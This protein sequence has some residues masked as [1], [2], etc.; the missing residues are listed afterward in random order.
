PPVS[1]PPP[2][3]P[4]PRPRATRARRRAAPA[5]DGQTSTAEV[6][7]ATGG[8]DLASTP[9]PGA[10][11]PP[12]RDGLT[13][14]EPPAPAEPGAKPAR[15]RRTARSATPDAGGAEDENGS[16]RRRRRA[17]AATQTELQLEPIPGD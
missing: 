12:E 9:G 17:P 8:E 10:E 16:S 4:E 5:A 11:A 14:E 7:P 15:R 1:A 2:A 6:G 3:E 13:P